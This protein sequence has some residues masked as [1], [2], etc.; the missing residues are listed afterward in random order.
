MKVSY[1]KYIVLVLL[2][3]P[4]KNYIYK[5]CVWI[6]IFEGMVIEMVFN[7]EI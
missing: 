3:Y 1:T 2:Y 7:N 4:K 6:K 5:S